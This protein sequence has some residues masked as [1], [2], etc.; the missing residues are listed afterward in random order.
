MLARRVVVTTLGVP[1]ERELECVLG[2][3]RQLRRVRPVRDL[4]E[5]MLIEQPREDAS[6]ATVVSTNDGGD[7]WIEV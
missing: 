6:L 2:P 1:L 5:E 4:S 7:Q 3:P